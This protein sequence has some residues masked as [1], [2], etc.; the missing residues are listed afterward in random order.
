MLKRT[1]RAPTLDHVGPQVPPT[2][3]AVPVDD[4]DKLQ[5]PVAYFLA[6]PKWRNLFRR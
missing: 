3:R 4:V 1:D 6:P 5:P 2:G